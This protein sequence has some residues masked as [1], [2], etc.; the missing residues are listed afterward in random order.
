MRMTTSLK[1]LLGIQHLLVTGSA[2]EDGALVI[3]VPYLPVML[4]AP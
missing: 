1:K 3:E 4:L 2:V